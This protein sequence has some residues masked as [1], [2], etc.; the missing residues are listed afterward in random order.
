MMH[1]PS[2][3]TNRITSHFRLTLHPPPSTLITTLPGALCAEHAHVRG[4]LDARAAPSSPFLAVTYRYINLYVQNMHTFAEHLTPALVE[5]DVFPN[6]SSGFSDSVPAL[7][8]LTVKSL[9]YLVPKL[10]ER[11]INS[12]VPL[13]PHPSPLTPKP[14]IGGCFRC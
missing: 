10:S 9:I 14:C 8:E 1:D 11:V 13:T 7:R 5:N 6:L 3:T 12:Q 4:A 2:L